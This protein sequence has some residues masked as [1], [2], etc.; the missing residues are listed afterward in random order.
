M[1]LS[2]NC[3]HQGEDSSIL[4]NRLVLIE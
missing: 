2:A 3:G 1:T 4:K